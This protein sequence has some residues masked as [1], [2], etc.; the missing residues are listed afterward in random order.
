MIKKQFYIFFTLSFILFLGSCEDSEPQNEVDLT[1]V[2]EDSG[3]P[4]PDD[5]NLDDTGEDSLLSSDSDSYD[6]GDTGFL[7]LDTEDD[8][9][10]EETSHDTLLEEPEIYEGCGDMPDPDRTRWVVVSHPYDASMAQTDVYEVFE[11]SP[12]GELSSRNIFFNMGRT[13]WGEIVF[14][15]DGRIGLVVQD[16]G[17]I[18]VF[19]FEDDGTPVVVYDNFSD[20]FYAGT[21]EMHPSG[22]M[23]YVLD[24]NWVNNGGGIF[25]IDLACDGTLSNTQKLGE[26]KLARG[27]EKILSGSERYVIAAADMEEPPILD[28]HMVD[29]D[30]GM[31]HIFGVDAF[32]DEEAS[33]STTAITYD[34]RYVLIADN[35]GFSG[36]PNRIAVVEVTPDGLNAVQILSPFR[37]PSSIVTS[38]FNNAAL[39]CAV[40]GDAIFH[41]SYDP[42][43]ITAPFEILGEPD[44][45]ERGPALP[46]SAALIDRGSLKGRVL[47]SENVGIRQVQFN[48]DGT[49]SDLGVL[50]LGSG[51]E[52]ICGAIGVTP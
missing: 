12:E 46:D 41:L 44:Y 21:I 45:L 15:P 17:T 13:F 10:F 5:T 39:V 36:I 20:G 7:E 34:G 38:P 8:E 4:D 1:E 35:S 2:T 47:I 28:A 19:R 42:D 43:N 30:S 50:D 32:G 48:P 49:L 26:L 14:T 51:F 23:I 25:R 22:E 11:L 29:L 6:T 40:Q 33:V 3:Q 9:L 52:K 27:I 31:S 18:G 16:D 24:S 37:D